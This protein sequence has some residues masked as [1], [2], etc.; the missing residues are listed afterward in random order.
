MEPLVSTQSTT[1]V[2]SF[3]P[4]CWVGEG[5]QAR[6]SCT[7]VHPSTGVHAALPENIVQLCWRGR[8]GR[9]RGWADSRA[10]DHTSQDTSLIKG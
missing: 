7:L 6:R 8:M 3:V 9:L 1:R 2:G 10:I 4:G 5:V